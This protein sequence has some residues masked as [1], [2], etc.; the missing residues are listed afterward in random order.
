VPYTVCVDDNFHYMDESE[1]YSLGE[2]ATAAQAVETCQKIVDEFLRQGFKPG[3][4]WQDLYEGYVGFGED[5]FIVGEPPVR[6]S[7]WDYARRRCV[8]MC[9]GGSP[10][11]TL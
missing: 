5:P 6:F 3:M 4:K 7:A 1:R 2:F 8:E 9:A 11:E 10:P